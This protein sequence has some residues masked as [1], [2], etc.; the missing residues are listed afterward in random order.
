MRPSPITWFHGA[1][2]AVHA[3]IIR[4]APDQSIR[5]ALLG[6]PIGAK[7]HRAL[8]LGEQHR[9][10]LALASRRGGEVRIFLREVLWGVGL[11]EGCRLY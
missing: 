7:R 4:S 8:E 6:I 2:V 11:V 3:A 1:L 10:L 9:A 5:R